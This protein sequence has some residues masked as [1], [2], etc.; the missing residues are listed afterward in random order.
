MLLAAEPHD[1]LAAPFRSRLTPRKARLLSVALARHHWHLL[2][3]PSR[4]AVLVG[5]RYADGLVG[6]GTVVAR[7]GAG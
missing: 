7:M 3:E 6:D 2:P 5:E 1:F 4:A